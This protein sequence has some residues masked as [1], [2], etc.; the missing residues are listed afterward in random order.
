MV[1][2]VFFIAN[3]IAIGAFEVK[4]DVEFWTSISISVISVEI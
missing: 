1:A 3:D 2:L 4:S